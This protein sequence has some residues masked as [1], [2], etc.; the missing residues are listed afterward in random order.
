MNK[1]IS[2]FAGALILLAA[3]ASTALAAPA[4][5]GTAG[6]PA[7][8]LGPCNDGKPPGFQ[9]QST[10]AFTSTRDHT[11]LSPQQGAEIYLANLNSADPP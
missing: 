1:T 5:D 9:V 10:I 7:P 8:V 4:G 6:A 3:T 2:S 11:G